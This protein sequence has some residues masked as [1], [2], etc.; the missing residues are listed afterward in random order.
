MVPARRGSKDRE[1]G[2]PKWLWRV[3]RDHSLR[4]C[5]PTTASGT[6]SVEAK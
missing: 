4:F 1:R 6:L 3:W 2:E 5:Q